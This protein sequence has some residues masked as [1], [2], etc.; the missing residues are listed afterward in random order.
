[1]KVLLGFAGLIGV[2]SAHHALI[3]FHVNGVSNMDCVRVASVNPI[4]DLGSDAMACGVV[5]G[6]AKTKCKVKGKAR[7][8]SVAYKE[9]HTD[10]SSR[11]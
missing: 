1:M 2:A 3:V 10:N 8:H 6:N 5:K 9:L 7:P 11:R 4:T